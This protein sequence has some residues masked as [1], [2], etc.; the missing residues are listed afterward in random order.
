MA[1]VYLKSELISFS[2]PSSSLVIHMF[3][4]EP[5]FTNGADCSGFVLSV[6][7]KY[8]ISLP[9]SSRAQAQ[10]GKQISLSE[11]K[12]GDLVF[13]SSG[14]RINHVAIYIGGGQVV[15]ASNPK[16]GIR[17][18]GATYRTVSTVRRIIND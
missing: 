18:S 5:A 2:M 16:T 14:G 8:G 17:I 4:E 9:H 12:P 6:F 15:H 1:R 10:M 11:A 7:K 3:G 13:Y